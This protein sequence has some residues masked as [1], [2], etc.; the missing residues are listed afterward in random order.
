MS[1]F[2]RFSTPQDKTLKKA[3]P[4]PRVLVAETKRVLDSWRPSNRH[5][6]L[7]EVL[8]LLGE[9]R[10]YESL[11]VYLVLGDK[12]KLVAHQGN[13]PASDSLGFGESNIGSAAK[14]GITKS[15]DISVGGATGQPELAV[16]I[17]LAA[18]V[19][20]VLDV[21]STRLTASD[22]ILVHEV[23]HL[24]ARFLTSNGKHLVR[25]AREKA[26]VA[27]AESAAKPYRATSDKNAADATARRA[28]AGEVSRA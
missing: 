17:K 8:E 23:A 1:W 10:G 13:T 21:E 9:G 11:S 5:S 16:P 22:N 15:K 24:I 14:N 25:K 27:V 19:L 3:H 6:P 26:A 4:S 28:A 2:P 7:D 18:R 12:V 20:G